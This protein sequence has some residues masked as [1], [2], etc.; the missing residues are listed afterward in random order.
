MSVHNSLPTQMILNFGT[1]MQKD[2]VSAADGAR[3]MVL[4]AFALVGTWKPDSDAAFA[5][6]CQAVR[7]GDDW[8]HHRHQEP[9]SRTALTPA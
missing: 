8:M 4:G 5:D 2:A 1:E 7:D 9:G 6:A 3:R